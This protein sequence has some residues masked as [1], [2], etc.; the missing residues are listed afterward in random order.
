MKRMLL[1]S[2][3]T[4]GLFSALQLAAGEPPRLSVEERV[5]FANQ[6]FGEDLLQG[7]VRMEHVRDPNANI[8]L[9]PFSA[10]VALSLLLNGAAGTTYDG[11]VAALRFDGLS[12][13][14]VNEANQAIL[15]RYNPRP[16]KEDD[17]PP[18]ALSVANSIWGD[19]ASPFRFH[20]SYIEAMQTM[21]EAE[22]RTLEFDA[23]DSAAAINAWASAAT[24]GRIQEVIGADTL[25]E[26]WFLLINATY[27]KANWEMEFA[28]ELTHEAGFTRA[29]GSKAMVK[30]ME[31]LETF[32]YFEDESAQYV[33]LPYANSQ[34]SMLIALPKAGRQ[35]SNLIGDESAG[36]AG[37]TTIERFRSNAKPGFVKLSLPKFAFPYSIKLRD[38]LANMGMSE[39]FTDAADFSLLGTP[40]TKVDFVKQDTFVK[41]DERG[42]EAAA[43]STIGGVPTSAPSEPVRMSVERP[44]LVMV[45]DDE[46]ALPI[47]MGVVMDPKWSGR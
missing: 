26:L 17:A 47:F 12:L 7:T 28:P 3:W 19:S 24:D 37:P 21:Y 42:T 5:A 46:L 44:F 1:V 9:S 16:E 15:A 14:E 25:A 38:V 23:P 30:M 41:L 8:F 27:F 4:I 6:S 29:D 45:M 11:V 20:D 43:I 40:A 39:A 18:F 34:I 36:F 31:H 10:S 35:L 22:V 2:A 13:A 33:R 32:Y